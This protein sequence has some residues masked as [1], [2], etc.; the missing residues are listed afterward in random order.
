MLSLGT[1]TTFIGTEG[2]NTDALKEP[3]K[4]LLDKKIFWEIPSSVLS[5]RAVWLGFVMAVNQAL[6]AEMESKRKQVV[7]LILKSLDD[8]NTSVC[9]VSWN[10]LVK[11]L[12]DIE[13]NGRL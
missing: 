2:L 9:A 10:C 5:A 12:K 1:M 11:F 13:V 6:P 7:A 8:E 4:S 3:I